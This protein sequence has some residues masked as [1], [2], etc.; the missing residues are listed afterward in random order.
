MRRMGMHA[1]ILA[2]VM[3][4]MAD[5][6]AAATCRSGSFDQ[7]MEGFKREASAK[8]IGARA[9]AALDGVAYSPQVVALDRRQGVFKKSFEEFGIPRVNQRL[10]KARGMM[11]RHAAT[12][13]RIE[14]QFGVPGGVVVAI[15]GLETDFG[16]N[17]GKQPALRALATLAYDC[18]RTAMFQAELL[19]ALRIIDRGDLTAA[20]MRGA[21]AGELG[22]TQFLPSSYMKFA[23]DFDGNGRRDLIRSV[24]DVLGSTANY[25]KSYGWKR[26]EGFAEGS[27]NFSVFKQWNRSGVYQKTIAYF[28]ERLEGE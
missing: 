10:T 13:A 3:A 21:W 15:W 18:R 7:W 22:Q 8:G 28:A 6:A 26:G 23:I 11:Q 19:D 16:V 27:H 24:P 25:L 9:L 5:S 20:E 2:A 1:L 14:R 12:L 4:L 17:M